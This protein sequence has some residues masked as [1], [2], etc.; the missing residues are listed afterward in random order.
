MSLIQA[1]YTQLSPEFG[2][3]IDRKQNPVEIAEEW[4][5][6]T[7]IKL[8]K[9]AEVLIQACKV[10]ELTPIGVKRIDEMLAAESST[11]F[12]SGNVSSNVQTS[13]MLPPYL[14][15]SVNGF[16]KLNGRDIGPGDLQRTAL[17]TMQRSSW[18]S[19][20]DKAALA[21][22]EASLHPVHGKVSRDE[23]TT[24]VRVMHLRSKETRHK[25]PSPVIT[26]GW[27]LIGDR[28]QIHY[29]KQLDHDVVSSLMMERAKIALSCE[30]T[31]SVDLLRIGGGNIV[32]VAPSVLKLA[33]ELGH[34]VPDKP[35][36]SPAEQD[37]A[38]N[39]SPS[40]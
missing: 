32:F 13:L 10:P 19:Q 33:Q 6:G 27:L 14:R 21:E 28:G 2:Q 29:E 30:H 5:W 31:D 9:H 34:I 40:P 3:S 25:Q 24:V 20:A 26:H 8:F 35:A 11:G 4:F 39:S 38:G 36:L 7:H 15:L 12:M 23:L 1:T 18:N 37:S 16:T 17:D 22:I